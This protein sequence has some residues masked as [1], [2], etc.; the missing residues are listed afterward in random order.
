MD[1]INSYL[2]HYSHSIKYDDIPPEVVHKVKVLLIDTIACAFGG[3]ASEPGKI[4]R[5]IAGALSQCN[6]PAT[7]LGSGQ[8]STPDLA[9]FANG[10][11]IR[12]L[13]FNDGFVSKGKGHPSDNF[14]PVLTCGDAVHANGK[15][16]ILA[17]TL[18]YEVFGRFADQYDPNETNFDHA[19]N[20]VFSCVMGAAKILGLSPQQIDEAINLAVVPN[21]SLQQTR[22][23][24]LSMWKSAALANAARNA[25]FACLLAK[26]GMTGPSPIFEGSGGFFKT[27]GGTFQLE[28]FG[29]NGR[30][31]RIMES[32]IK[33]YPCGMYAQTA[34]DAAI[35]L[36]SKIS[37]LDEITEIK[38]GIFA[39]GMRM[40]GDP[41]KWHP[42][43]RETADHSLPYVIG[44]AMMTNGPLEVKH[45]SDAYLK[46]EKLLEFIQKIKVEVTTE[47]DDLFPD[48]SASRLTILTK[49]GK[50]FSELV[51]HHRGHHQNPLDDKELEEKFHSLMQDCF[52]LKKREKILKQ[53]WNLENVD[54]IS[55]IME[56][57]II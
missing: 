53:L 5:K 50:Q 42:Q 33:R 37:A 35:Q 19:V 52:P 9:T 43:T 25:V 21:L 36:R 49:S 13:D 28:E 30:P 48:A 29:G 46:N 27:I 31:F 34:I 26:E 40:A 12:Y 32:L 18:A 14:A 51:C 22:V 41:E 8:K 16:V 11:M 23:G 47:C 54:N 20:G 57:M 38:V 56:L 1:T 6:M 45:F 24:T 44:V 10:V 39:A 3:Y 15:E 55:N 2:A 4:A 7:V 17:A